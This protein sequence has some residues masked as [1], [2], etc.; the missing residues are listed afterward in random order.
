[1]KYDDDDYVPAMMATATSVVVADGGNGT[2]P[3]TA[4]TTS[5]WQQ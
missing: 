2:V 4:A 1:M 3:A 5:H